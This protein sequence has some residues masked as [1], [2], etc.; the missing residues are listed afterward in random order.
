[1]GVCRF[2]FFVF[3]FS[4]GRCVLHALDF[5]PQ[6]T[7]EIPRIRHSS[8]CKS[9]KECGKPNNNKK[10]W[11]RDFDFDPKKGV[12]KTKEIPRIRHRSA[13]KFPTKKSAESL[14]LKKKKCEK[15]QRNTENPPQICLQIYGQKVRKNPKIKRLITFFPQILLFWPVGRPRV[16]SV[17][18]AVDSDPRA[19][20][21]R[22]YRP[23]NMDDHSF[24]QFWYKITNFTLGTH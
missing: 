2:V 4:V 1:M 9:A 3:V 12:R 5:E 16:V 13:C 10:P 20:R 14:I 8:G 18:S 17:C 23:P 24:G 19:V 15:N 22:R 7:N 21:C 11:C 6:K